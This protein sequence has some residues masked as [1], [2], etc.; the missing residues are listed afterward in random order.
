MLQAVEDMYSILSPKA[1]FSTV[2]HEHE[3]H[4]QKQTRH[5]PHPTG[6][7]HT[8]ILCRVKLRRHRCMFLCVTL[9]QQKMLLRGLLASPCPCLTPQTLPLAYIVHVGA[10]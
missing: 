2:L 6:L 1:C 5:L 3:H 8:C 7:H 10:P 4:T 9:I